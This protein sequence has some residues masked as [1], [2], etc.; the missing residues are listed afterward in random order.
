MRQYTTAQ[1][2]A[3]NI[4]GYDEPIAIVVLISRQMMLV[5]FP[6][7]AFQVATDSTKII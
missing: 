1:G 6:I 2:P 5:S 3:Q 4:D 7:V